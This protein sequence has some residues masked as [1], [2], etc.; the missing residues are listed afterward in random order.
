MKANYILILLAI[1]TMGATALVTV[2]PTQVV[3]S[4][5]HSEASSLA[6]H[7]CAPGSRTP[8]SKARSIIAIAPARHAECQMAMHESVERPSSR[9]RARW[10]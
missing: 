5:E 8:C 1:L 6:G 10:Q 7:E 3:M 4:A 2:C 9:I